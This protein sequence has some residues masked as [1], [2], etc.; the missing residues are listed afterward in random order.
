[1]AVKKNFKATQNLGDVKQILVHPPPQLTHSHFTRWCWH[2]IT[3]AKPP[4]LMSERVKAG[5]EVRAPV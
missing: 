1:M 5:A 4:F 3:T 2:T